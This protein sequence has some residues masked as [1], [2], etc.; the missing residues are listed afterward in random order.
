VLPPPPRDPSVRG[1]AMPEK[2]AN[3]AP[4]MPEVGTTPPQPFPEPFPEPPPV[5]EPPAESKLTGTLEK[6]SLLQKIKD[7]G[8]AGAVSYASWEL[9]FWGLSLPV[10]LFAYVQVEGHLPDLMNA[11]DLAKLSAEAFAFIN[12]ARLAVP[13]RLGLAISTVPWVQANIIDKLP[14]GRDTPE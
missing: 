14:W 5:A 10:C 2:M 9:A 13:V 3:G 12:L 6:K 7:A 8:V 11:D 1:M 4:R